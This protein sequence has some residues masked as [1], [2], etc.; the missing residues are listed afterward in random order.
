MIMSKSGRNNKK[1]DLKKGDTVLIY[2]DPITE[3]G[4]E[5]K[6]KLIECISKNFFDLGKEKLERW[7]VRFLD[8]DTIYE[9]NI[10]TG[11]EIRS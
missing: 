7:K 1:M 6:A 8:K 4:V 11:K 2:L 10:K 5:G 9:R 3:T